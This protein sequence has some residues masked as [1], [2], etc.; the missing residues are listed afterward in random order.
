[1]MKIKF[2]L[3]RVAAIGGA[4]KLFAATRKWGADEA[5]GLATIF[6]LAT[7]ILVGATALG[8]DVSRWELA[9]KNLQRGADAAAISA[10]VAYQV[11]TTTN[12]K[13]Q[14]TAVTATYSLSTSNG[15]ALTVNRPPLSG[16]YTTNQNAVEVI[17]SQPQAGL[18]AS[19]FGQGTVSESGRAVAIGGAKACVL[20]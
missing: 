5:G 10:A 17:I 2:G 14:A 16:S 13:D 12:L 1:M 6:A 11:N 18:F 15:A 20:A 19:L 8:V 7:P 4:A 3:P 9:H